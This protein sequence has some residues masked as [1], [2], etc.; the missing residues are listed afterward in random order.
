VEQYE[1]GKTGSLPAMNP[2]QHR[3]RELALCR[4][5]HYPRRGS[6]QASGRRSRPD[7]TMEL[8]LMS[9]A[10]T[11]TLVVV[12]IVEFMH[13]KPVAEHA[14]SIR[15]I[16]PLLTDTETLTA[17]LSVAAGYGG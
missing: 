7:T 13:R 1:T 5:T 17:T 11:M 6:P 8:L 15:A 2:A 14:S 4:T 9:I 16:P 3:R 10:G 12:Q